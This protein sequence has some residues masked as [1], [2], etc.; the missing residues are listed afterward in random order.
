MVP[1]KMNNSEIIK[2]NF[3]LI[4][5]T[6]LNYSNYCGDYFV[7]GGSGSL[8]IGAFILKNYTNI[9]PHY[10]A[11]ITLFF[12]KIDDWNN[13][14]VMV[15]VDEIK[16]PTSLI[17]N[18]LND[19]SI[20]KLCGNL[21]KT[22]AIRPVDLFFPHN[23]SNLLLKISTNLNFTP[24]IASWG[25][26]N[27]S[28]SIFICYNSCA[29]CQGPNL[30]DCLSC[31]SGLF[32][33]NYSEYSVCQPDCFDGY[34]ADFLDNIC[35]LCDKSCLN[36]N[37]NS[38]HCLSCPDPNFLYNFQCLNKCPNEMVIYVKDNY[39]KVC[40]SSCPNYFYLNQSIC[41]ACFYLCKTCNGRENNSC[42]SCDYPNYLFKGECLTKCPSK[43]YADNE[44]FI[45]KF[46]HYSCHECIDQYE[47]NCTLCNNET[48]KLEIKNVSLNFEK[49]ISKTGGLCKCIH[50]YY[51]MMDNEYCLR[52]NIF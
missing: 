12:M 38:T 46:C 24:D 47:N 18:S 42:L 13:N 43:T 3:I 17:F 2:S 37:I 40:L 8:G 22:E 51:D 21:S 20:M 52:I 28:V 25:I 48:R 26:Y 31:N 41:E 29:T 16:L 32:L 39:I 44:T 11:R 9:V 1:D 23:S 19:S 6:S 34:Y 49:N 33:Q 50:K 10:N 27:L 45:C 4:N 5:V 30:T 14:E 7:V 36:C 35:K 15:F